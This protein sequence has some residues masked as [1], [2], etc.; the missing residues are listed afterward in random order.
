MVGR[1]AHHGLT[2]RTLS[3]YAGIGLR[4]AKA[5]RPTQDPQAG[6]LVQDFGP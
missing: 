4:S 5:L 6:A 1:R 2:E 3:Q